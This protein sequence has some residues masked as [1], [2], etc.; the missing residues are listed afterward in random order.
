MVTLSADKVLHASCVAVDGKAVLIL[1][2]SGAGKSALAL[3]LMAY[4]ARLVADDQV[5]LRVHDGRVIARAPSAIA[6]L[7]EARGMGILNAEVCDNAPLALVVDLDEVEVE[8]MPTLRQ[9]TVSGCVL[10]L[11]KRIDSLHFAPAI[12][13]FLRAGRS[14]R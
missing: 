12:L 11:F 13:Q 10:P 4:G 2:Q 7:V 3:T 6:G 5:D 1:G 9:V 8:R 14:E